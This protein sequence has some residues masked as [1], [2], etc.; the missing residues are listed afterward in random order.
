M[1]EEEGGRGGGGQVCRGGDEAVV[2]HPG[3]G[4]FDLWWRKREKVLVRDGD[5]PH[6]SASAYLSS[7]GGQG[8]GRENV[9][10]RDGGLPGLCTIS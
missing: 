7:S 8:R 9:L 4:R 5:L 2:V 10:V 1:S 3:V 6:L